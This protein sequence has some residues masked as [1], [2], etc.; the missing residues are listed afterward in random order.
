VLAQGLREPLV[1]AMEQRYI[2]VLVM[3]ADDLCADLYE[4]LGY[5]HFADGQGVVAVEEGRANAR[6]FFAQFL[7]DIDAA[8]LTS[9]SD[10][11]RRLGAYLPTRVPR[12]GVL[13]TAARQGIRIVTPDFATSA[14]GTLLLAAQATGTAISLDAAGDVITLARTL[15]ERPH[16]GVLRV[17]EGAADAL[18]A[19]ARELASALDI[20][21]PSLTSYVTLG[22]ARSA[23]GEGVHLAADA[24]LTLPLLITGL[25]Q[26][27]SHVRKAGADGH[28]GAAVE[29]GERHEEPALA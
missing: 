10:L 2:D 15:A 5:S 28:R 7:A 29:S 20:E 8:G 11:W 16:L 22:S 24:S 26:R 1:Y 27:C 14:F 13:Q 21:A 19:Q 12:R 9:T 18:I 25:A 6:T 3:S 17:G 4:S 23:V